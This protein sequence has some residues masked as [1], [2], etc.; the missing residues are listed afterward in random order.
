M[1]TPLLV[2]AVSAIRASEACPYPSSA[3]VSMA[4]AT[5]WARRAVSVKVRVAS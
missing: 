4:A 3:M 1:I 2:P 5:I